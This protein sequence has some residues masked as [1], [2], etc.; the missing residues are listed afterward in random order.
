MYAIECNPRTHSAVTLFY[1][2]DAASEAYLGYEPLPSPVTPLPTGRPTYWI[3]HEVW[4]A[5][6]HLSD[7]K[8][9]RER[10]GIIARG[11]DAIFDWADP[12]P[13]LMVHHWQI[14]LLLIGD[15]R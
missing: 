3:Y 2:Q 1:S 4:R 14:P 10:L 5:L 9:L 11:K 7:P 13:F 15:L 6:S 12:L 8:A